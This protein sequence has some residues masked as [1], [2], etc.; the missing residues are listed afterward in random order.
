M[1]SPA[2]PSGVRT[3]SMAALLR[4]T[5]AA[6]L[7]VTLLISLLATACEP[8]E[9]PQTEMP[10]T[11]SPSAAPSG[12][13]DYAQIQRE[14]ADRLETVAMEFRRTQGD[15]LFTTAEEVIARY[16]EVVGGR[17]AFDTIRT[18]VMRLSGHGPMGQLVEIERYYKRPLHYRQ[19]ARG[20][21]S[22]AVTDGRHLWQVT[23]QGW[24]EVEGSAYF[25][26]AS[27]DG[28][29]IEYEEWGIS[30]E[31]LGVTALDSDPGYSVRRR[32]PDGSEETLF[33]SATSGLL[34]AVQSEYIIHPAS[35]FSYWDYRDLGGVR[36]PH[37]Q[38]RSVGELGPPHGAVVESVEINV[39]LPDSLFVPPEER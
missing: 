6:A 33:F 28:H 16:L 36:I 10:S 22:A 7:S 15:A 2:H 34:T 21:E 24:E 37:V 19:Q 32:W 20:S 14:W 30:Y 18:M 17:E 31:L 27:I 38:I 1:L 13:R 5:P 9:S 29:F 39:P 12:G 35:W 25:R 8:A 11:D 4:A 26:L 23:P 3:V